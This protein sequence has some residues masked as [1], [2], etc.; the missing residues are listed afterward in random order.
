[1]I[2]FGKKDQEYFNGRL[3]A[4]QLDEATKLPMQ[5]PPLKEYQGSAARRDNLKCPISKG[6]L[7]DYI[8]SLHRD[9]D[10]GLGKGSIVRVTYTRQFNDGGGQA[11]AAKF[12]CFDA[13]CQMVACS[14]SEEGNTSLIYWAKPEDLKF[15]HNNKVFE[16]RKG[17]SVFTPIH[18]HRTVLGRSVFWCKSE[19]PGWGC[20]SYEGVKQVPIFVVFYSHGGQTGLDT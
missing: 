14:G 10:T 17:D 16:I 19:R 2:V 1:M 3:Y 7:Q 8:A 6:T 5:P 9:K 4:L 20:I 12:A 18:G 13:F 11:P 15:E